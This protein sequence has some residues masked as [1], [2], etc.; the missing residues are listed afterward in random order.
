MNVGEWVY[1]L[2]SML[3]CKCVAI[4]WRASLYSKCKPNL[5]NVV[6]FSINCVI[7]IS[8]LLPKTWD[9]CKNPIIRNDNRHR[10]TNENITWFDALNSSTLFSFSSDLMRRT[11]PLGEIR[12]VSTFTTL[13]VLF[14]S[15][16]CA[17]FSAPL[18]VRPVFANERV[19]KC[20]L[21]PRASNRLLNFSSDMF[22][23]EKEWLTFYN[24]NGFVLRLL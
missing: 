14:F 13:I 20:V 9:L 17:N 6:F 22:W 5:N 10:S 21:L 24:L 15:I 16:A 11:M 3:R 2:V 1:L 7:S 12:L 4:R 23:K 19:S 8:I 18:S